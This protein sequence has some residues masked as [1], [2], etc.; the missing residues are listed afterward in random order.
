[1][2]QVTY[3]LKQQKFR[4]VQIENICSRQIKFCQSDDFNLLNGRIKCFQK[5]SSLGRACAAMSQKMLTVTL[6]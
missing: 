1:M 3:I 6:A 2:K 5:I 4:L